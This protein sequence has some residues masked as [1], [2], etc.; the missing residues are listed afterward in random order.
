MALRRKLAA[1]LLVGAGA[2]LAGCQSPSQ[3]GL[4]FWK[5]DSSSSFASATPDVGKQ[6]YENLAREFGGSSTSGASALG[7]TKP[8]ADDNFLTASWK[9]TTGAIGGA[10]AAKPSAG[11]TVDPLRLDQPMKKVGPEVHIGAAQLMENQGK[12]AD[13]EQHY[14]KALKLAPNDLNALV[15][16][17]RMHDR[18]GRASQALEVYQRALKAHPNS[19]L[20][21][22]DMGL[23]YARQKQFE[24]ALSAMTRAVELTPEN[25]KYRNN[26]ATVLVETGR[27]D[28][29]V[30]AMT[31]GSSAAV[32][33][34]NV[35]Y[36]L[37]QKGLAAD[38]TRH[39][40]QAL[41]I[42]PALA[43]AREMLAHLGGNFGAQ[44]LAQQPR[45]AAAP[46]YETARLPITAQPSG[47]VDTSAV[48]S[49]AIAAPGTT[50]TGTGYHLSDDS[51]VIESPNPANSKW[52]A[53]GAQHLPP[54]E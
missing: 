36:L 16:L 2:C 30:Q 33:H 52:G 1:T 6:K 48:Q 28:Q 27:I 18:Q 45:P 7:A 8:P 14:L 54:V 44:P 15:G 39:F 10:F 5:N 19:G 21:L 12:F 24:P 42:D 23:C 4:A 17:A 13:A 26:L 11:D 46:Q 35:G 38:A 41:A 40:Q 49:P 29:A 43:P 50:A 9:K 34:Y 51:P 53:Y 32:A 20:V 22:N 31:V 25:A 37:H 3:G 47:L